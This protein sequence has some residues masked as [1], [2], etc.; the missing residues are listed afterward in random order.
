MRRRHRGRKPRVVTTTAGEV[1]L[2][3]VYFECP[4]CLDG[5]Y[6]LDE[7]LGVAGRYSPQAQ[8]LI[9]LAAAS[10]SY[11]VSAER[12][13]E[14]CG[15]N[16]SDTTIRELAQQHGAAA[17]TW[18]REEPAAVRSFREATGDV[19]FSTD[20]TCV[21]TTEGWREMKV[22]LFA[23][24][25][26]G[27]AA[28][29]EEWDTRVLPPPKVRV[30]FAAVEDSQA[31]GQRWHA[32]RRRLGLADTS[33]VTVLA[34]GAKWIWEEQRRHLPHAAGVLDVFHALE[35]I[36]G[37]G[38]ALHADA[39]AIAAWTAAGR[40]A[41]LHGGWR[42]ITEHI[43]RRLPQPTVLQQAAIDQLLDY[44]APHQHHLNYAERLAQGRS[45]GSGQIEGACKNLIGR[46]LKQTGARWRVRRVNRM[47]GLCCL[48]YSHQWKTYWE[49]A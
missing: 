37:T 38:Q 47:A 25:A 21:N 19:E 45:I 40:A 33:G 20:G 6:A 22:G 48:L 15:L 12:L 5:G 24:R 44:L 29:P 23:K 34:D 46:R 42:G 8:R 32:W 43:A 14:L 7:R 16:V 18:L 26:R 1:R 2:S 39:A 28:R 17:N 36:A 3:R 13:A 11:D 9:C 41:L 4:V 31:F 30:A 10:W 49:S 35:H 27:V